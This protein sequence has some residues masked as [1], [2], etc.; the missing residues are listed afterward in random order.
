MV[1]ESW[2]RHYNTVCPHRPLGYKPPALETFVPRAPGSATRTSDNGR[3][4]VGAKTD[5]ELTLKPEHPSGA[6]QAL[7]LAHA[8]SKKPREPIDSWGLLLVVAGAGFEPAT[9][10]L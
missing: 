2:R 4:T 6:G 8:D 5:H 7:R 10:R 3:A 1:I 9:F